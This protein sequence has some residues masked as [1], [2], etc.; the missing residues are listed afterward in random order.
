[1]SFFHVLRFLR[2]YQSGPPGWK[3]SKYFF[4]VYLDRFQ[5]SKVN[6]PKFQRFGGSYASKTLIFMPKI[7]LVSEKV[8]VYTILTVA[9]TNKKE[10]VTYKTP[11]IIYNQNWIVSHSKI[12]C[13]INI[14][15]PG[16]CCPERFTIL[17]SL[18]GISWFSPPRWCFFTKNV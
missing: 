16:S 2:G 8:V 1:M 14:D 3:F 6:F 12:A 10:I 4:L 17:T 13:A 7:P 18:V 15:F 11:L 5:L 9:E